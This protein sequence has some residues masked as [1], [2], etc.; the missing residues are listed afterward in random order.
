MRNLSTLALGVCL[1]A[2]AAAPAAAE[3]TTLTISSWVS[4]QHPLTKNVVM[5]WA[6]GWGRGA[7]MEEVGEI[8]AAEAEALAS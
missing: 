2:L 1:A 6:A 8:V 3:T 7:T 5:V 4:P